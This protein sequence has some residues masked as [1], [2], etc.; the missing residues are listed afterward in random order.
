MRERELYEPPQR[1][2]HLLVFLS[3]LSGI[4][5]LRIVILFLAD[6]DGYLQ[7]GVHP[8]LFRYPFRLLPQY[9]ELHSDSSARPLH[10]CRRKTGRHPQLVVVSYGWAHV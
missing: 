3:H 6:H 9:I 7:N 4:V 8:L 5:P 1:Q 2:K 10:V